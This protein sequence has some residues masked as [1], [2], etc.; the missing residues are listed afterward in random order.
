M[1][2]LVS[3]FE[4]PA[5]DFT[6]AVKFYEVVLNT[7]LSVMDCGHEKM[8]FFSD[9]SSDAC[10]A[11]SWAEGFNPSK[12]GVLIHLNCN[13]INSTLAKIEENGGKTITAKTQ[14][15]ADNA[16]FFA[17]FLDCEGNRV[18]LWCEK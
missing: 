15:E 17:I 3:F 18:G 14:I 5:A 16:G 7:K 1:K 12:D 4:I 6:R 10:G 9:G 11:I 13:D 2:S 8:A